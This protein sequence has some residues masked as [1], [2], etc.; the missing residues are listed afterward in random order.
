MRAKRAAAILCASAIS[1]DTF[2]W[3]VALVTIMIQASAQLAAPKEIIFSIFWGSVALG[4]TP[5]IVRKHLVD[6]RKVVFTWVLTSTV[7]YAFIAYYSAYG[8]QAILTNPATL[9]TMGTLFFMGYPATLSYTSKQLGTRD[10]AGVVAG[11]AAFVVVAISGLLTS[12]AKSQSLKQNLF[13]ALWVRAAALPPAIYI[14]L[15]PP[16]QQ[17]LEEERIEWR[18]ALTYYLISL[19]VIWAVHPFMIARSM[20]TYIQHSPTAAATFFL[21]AMASL[22]IAGYVMDE[23]GRKR[24]VAYSIMA[25]GA[26]HS[27]LWGLTPENLTAMHIHAAILGTC[28][29]ILGVFYLVILA[30]DLSPQEKLAHTYALV[31]AVFAGAIALSFVVEPILSLSPNIATYIQTM[32]L[33]AAVGPLAIAPETLPEDI[34]RRKELMRYAK[35]AK[36]IVKRTSK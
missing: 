26:A 35:K 29:S 15:A 16:P 3:A 6:E 8:N 12:L 30:N 20:K 25:L 9:I 11:T 1:I 14:A 13:L 7:L 36:K 21:F 19:S 28:W 18:K 34:I 32:V 23:Y 31:M 22:P 2:C 27:L 4:M 17:R 33:F 10:R 24:V 5:L